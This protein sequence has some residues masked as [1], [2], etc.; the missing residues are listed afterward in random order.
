[1]L[2]D[3]CESEGQKMNH[4]GTKMHEEGYSCVRVAPSALLLRQ[5]CDGLA[6]PQR[7]RATAIDAIRVRTAFLRGPSFPSFL[8]GDLVIFHSSAAAARG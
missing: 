5:R 6:L 7:V 1:V 2:R 8:R 3:R 4:E